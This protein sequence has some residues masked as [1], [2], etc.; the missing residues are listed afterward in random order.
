[1]NDGISAWLILWW[2][3]SFRFSL[4]CRRVCFVLTLILF[5]SIPNF[6]FLF[7]CLLNPMY[8]E[9]VGSRGS[10]AVVDFRSEYALASDA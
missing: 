4:Y 7:Q 8:W 6:P 3:G 5:T 9:G 10:A 2:L 1:M